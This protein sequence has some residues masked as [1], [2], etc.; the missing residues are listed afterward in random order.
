MHQLRS[1]GLIFALLGLS[2]GIGER[3]FHHHVED[4]QDCPFR[5]MHRCFQS[6]GETFVT[7]RFVPEPRLDVVHWTMPPLHTFEPIASVPARAP[8]VAS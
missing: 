8:P 2:L 5:A 3:Y 6:G 7:P 1:A 4:V